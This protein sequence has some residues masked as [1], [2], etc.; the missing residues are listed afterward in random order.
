MTTGTAGFL[1]LTALGT[2]LIFAQGSTATIVGTVK[3][4]SGAVLPGTAVTVKHL[5]TGL[6]RTDAADSSGNFNIPSLP[7]GPY[8]VTAEK[9]G[10]RR[11]V[12]RG[13]NLAV[14]E[15]AQVNLTL[16]V[17]SI[18]QQV[19]VTCCSRLPTCRTKFTT[20]S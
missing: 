7:V 1:A 19:T 16:Q 4:V 18:D 13:I 17:G 11:E 8:E 5:E 12:R 3:D 2:G 6:T 20:A 14:A 10:F 15:E 9:M